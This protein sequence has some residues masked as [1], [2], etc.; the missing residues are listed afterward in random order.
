MTTVFLFLS[1]R[2]KDIFKFLDVFSLLSIPNFVSLYS[3]EDKSP[4]GVESTQGGKA[5]YRAR[6]FLP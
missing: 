4:E 6:T 2:F 1:P 5:G 3:E